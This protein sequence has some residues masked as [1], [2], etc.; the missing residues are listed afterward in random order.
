MD[1]RLTSLPLYPG[2]PELP[3]TQLGCGRILSRIAC[4]LGGAVLGFF[5]GAFGYV[6]LCTGSAWG[7]ALDVAAMV[8]LLVGVAGA[9]LGGWV[10]FRLG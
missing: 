9:A 1:E 2:G 5:G 8:A 6:S 3:P 7:D 10:G 4:G